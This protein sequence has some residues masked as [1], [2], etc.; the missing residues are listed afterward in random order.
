[1][2]G[3][4]SFA[5]NLRFGEGREASRRP[6]VMETLEI[7]DPTLSTGNDGG[8]WL[9][10]HPTQRTMGFREVLL[11]APAYSPGHGIYNAVRA[12]STVIRQ[13]QASVLRN[14]LDGVAFEDLAD[15]WRAHISARG[16]AP[17]DLAE[18]YWLEPADA[19]RVA[20]NATETWSFLLRN[21]LLDFVRRVAEYCIDGMGGADGTAAYARYVDWLTCLG[22]VPVIR[23]GDV[24]DDSAGKGTERFVADTEW[25]LSMQNRLRLAPAIT[26]RGY[27]MLG[28]LERCFRAA[29]VMNYDRTVVIMH[30]AT[31]ELRAYDVHTRERGGCVVAWDP[32]LTERGIVFDSPMQRLYAAVLRTQAVREHAKLCQLANTAPVSVLV[33]RR[34]DKVAADPAGVSKLV[35][36][37]LGEGAEEAGQS[38][39]AK[40]IKF[41]I[42]MQN[43]RK[44]GDVAEVV[45]AYLR[46]SGG[47]AIDKTFSLDPG[48]AGFG[49]NGKSAQGL[50]GQQGQPNQPKDGV[51][52]VMRDAVNTSVGKVVNN[53]FKAVSDLKS[54]NADL[55][56]RNAHIAKELTESRRR[57]GALT[58]AAARDNSNGSSRYD[59][60]DAWRVLD[61]KDARWEMGDTLLSL[62][63]LPE[64]VTMNK[65]DLSGE[66]T[67]DQY[68]A[69]SFF[70]RYVP[71][72]LEEESRLSALWEREL[73][74]VFKMHRV[75]NNQ[76]DEVSISYS[77]SSISLIVG[78]FFHRV[79]KATR[80]GFLVADDE[81]YKSEEELCESLFKKSRVDAYLRDLKTTYLADVR[82]ACAIRKIRQEPFLREPQDVSGEFERAGVGADYIDGAETAPWPGDDTRKK[83][84]LANRGL[85]RGGPARQRVEW[86]RGEDHGQL[87]ERD[88]RRSV[89]RWWRT[90]PYPTREDQRSGRGRRGMRQLR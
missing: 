19:V 80:L 41:I 8:E 3:G 56:R 72:Y 48:R 77:N 5:Q 4:C 63:N 44:V 66:M 28:C 30:S 57:I 24:A 6:P 18:K 49:G 20:E 10:I 34:E 68:V 67:E 11:G 64:S 36:K 89:P 46:E 45:D 70:S 88:V 79:L 1:M 54:A 78:P 60:P 86:E 73:L 85:C 2:E 42:D 35:D 32:M 12:T 40:L 83:W 50:L 62:G 47:P 59:A 17:G 13:V 43:M 61:E 22:I 33:A 65:V 14:I 81:A 55:T 16:F 25:D 27:D 90:T 7:I 29:R 58:S 38:A 9:L 87:G 71:P 39:A 51:A 21:L 53:L 74:R 23:E 84:D 15:D 52:S 76:G 69:N 31:R 82:N 75:T 26:R 37:A